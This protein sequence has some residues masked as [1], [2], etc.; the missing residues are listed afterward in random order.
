MQLNSRGRAFFATPTGTVANMSL[1]LK[2]SHMVTPVGPFQGLTNGATQ[3]G[4]SRRAARPRL[5]TVILSG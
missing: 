2:G 1:T 4:A 3:P 5:L